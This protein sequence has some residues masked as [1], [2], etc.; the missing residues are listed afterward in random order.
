MRYGLLG[1]TL[2]HSHSPLIYAQL[3]IADYRLF[4]T[5]PDGVESLIRGGELAGLNV[6][7]PYKKTV[8][9]FCDTLSDTAR[10]LGN[11]NVLRFD[12]NGRIHGDNT[13]YAG[14]RA[15]LLR[16]G[17]AVEGRKVAILGTG[18]AAQT[19][20][21]VAH[22]LGARTVVHVS[23]TGED[24]YGN[25][26][27][28]A[29]AQLLIN[30][31]PVGMYPNCDAAPLSLDCFE[32]LEGVVDL[33]Y[34][35]LRTRLLQQ[36]M[37]RGVRCAGGLFMLA[38]QGRAAAEIFLG[39]AIDPAATN[40]VYAALLQKVEGIALV[41]MPGSGKTAVAQAVAA[42]MQ[43]GCIDLDASIAGQEGKS[44]AQI[45]E[46]DGESA[47]RTIE[48]EVLQSAACEGGRVMATG[49]GAVL[50]AENRAALRQN[51]RVYWL[52]RPLS[53]LETTGRP[54]SKDL[55]ALYERRRPAYEAAA[56]VMIDT[57]QTPE[58]TARKIVE[59][60]YEYTR[61]Q[62]A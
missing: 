39:H 54:L 24:N 10:R 20:A 9:P 13:D 16:G 4:E 44:P 2:A 45:I 27:R 55:P 48:A 14:L 35:P 26:D 15:T 50:R 38:E 6:T 56:D 34:N 17:F 1:K 62:W 32:A 51:S 8:M 18:G 7:I 29:D 3:G 41:G 11:V 49:G 37:Q 57:Q 46:Q 21:A 19:A 22:D 36:A 59:E 31:T 23:R 58:E 52:K 47:F 61:T 43:R 25:L 53:E 60:F 40:R 5:P 28:R 12:S 30:A 33:V 42:L